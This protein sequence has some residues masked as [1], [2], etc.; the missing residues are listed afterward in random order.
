M[1]EIKLNQIIDV[2]K[3]EMLTDW[4]IKIVLKWK[5]ES[6]REKLNKSFVGK[7]ITKQNLSIKKNNIKNY[8]FYF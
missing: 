4:A 6:D 2:K 3:K 1:K 7:K 8:F 5:R